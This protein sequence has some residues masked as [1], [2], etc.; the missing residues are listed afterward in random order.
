MTTMQDL[1]SDTRRMAYGSLGDQINLVATEYTANDTSL[2]L[3]MDV[4]NITQGMMLSSGLNVWY[5][6]G[7]DIASK[8]VFVIPGYDNAPKTNL[9]VGEFVYIKPRVTDWFL[10]ETINQEIAHLSSPDSG[11][12]KIGMWEVPVDPTWQTYAIPSGAFNMIGL[13]RIRFRMPGSTDVWIDVPEKAY[14]V[15]INP[16][17]GDS[18]IRLLRNIPSGTNLQF[19]YKAPFTRAS[20][21]TDDVEAVCGLTDTMMDIPP[22]GALGSLLRTTESRRMQVQQ[23]GDARR[24]TEV[25][26]GYNLQTAQ[27]VDREYRSRVLE[28]MARLVQRVPLVRSL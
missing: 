6:K 26:G 3:D 19:L 18:Y 15:Q 13:L 2:I 5:T 1:I 17:F 23:Q 4:S 24:A 10:F 27:A 8:T 22:L 21:L 7:T 28:E 25:S 20:A 9:S 11:L 16:T 12:Y 14:R